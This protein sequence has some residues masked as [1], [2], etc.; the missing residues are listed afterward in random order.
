LSVKDTQSKSTVSEFNSQASS[1][2]LAKKIQQKQSTINS[3][4]A[5]M[6]IKDL[7]QKLQAQVQIN[8]EMQEKLNREGHRAT[9]AEQRLQIVYKYLQQIG[10]NP[11]D[12]YNPK[13]S[14]DN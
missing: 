12:I 7:E 9:I 1:A 10:I 13:S 8:A 4:Q 2:D 11:R 14:T 5:R 3:D 6:I